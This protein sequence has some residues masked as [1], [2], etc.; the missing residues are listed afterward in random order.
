MT[1]RVLRLEQLSYEELDDYLEQGWFRIGQTLMT[2]R[3]VLFDGV[4][5]T[6]LWTRLPL[7]GHRFRKSSRKLL[8]RTRRNFHIDVLEDVVLDRR[9]EALYQRY[10]QVA[11]GERSPTLEDFLYG[12]GEERALF[13]TR[14]IDVWD[15]DRLVA[16][17]WFDVGGSASQSLMGV[18]DPDYAQH[19]LG[20]TTMLLE[21]DYSIDLGMDY[22]YP[23]YVLPGEPAMD[24]KL[25]V[26]PVEF[27][28]PD[29]LEWRPWSEVDA[30]E[31]SEVRL[32]RALE[33]AAQALRSAGIRVS[34]QMYPMFEAPAWHD[35]L[36]GC[37]D[38]PLV[39]VCEPRSMARRQILVVYDLVEERFEVLRCARAS[40]V[41]VTHDGDVGRP[42]ELWLTEDTL[43]Q[44]AFPDEVAAVVARRTR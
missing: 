4:L 13:D 25:R 35:Q 44:C 26:G 21:V 12:D 42:I 7:R 31:L 19:S 22:F 43:A 10:R 2:C 41:A 39:L 16:F 1:T 28:D 11:R 24:Y 37:L 32:R 23:G 18:Y 5:R 40:A 14:E 30:H 20:Y 34:L 17:S 3:I 15:G 38:A 29:V 36:Q 9:R 27:H 6:A 33:A 8:N